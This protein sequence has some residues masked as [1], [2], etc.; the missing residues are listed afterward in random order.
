MA[1]SIL[2]DQKRILPCAAFLKGEYGVK[3]LFIGVLC[4][5]GG[6]GM[7]KVIEVK[8]NDTERAGLENSTKAVREL[9]E[10]L[11]KLNL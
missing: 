4:Q 1:E 10:A 11:G 6:A 7:E 3:D 9:T 8:L 5:L 2:R